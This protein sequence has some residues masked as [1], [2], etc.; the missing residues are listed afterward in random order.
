MCVCGGGGGVSRLSVCVCVHA[1]MCGELNVCVGVSGC[2]CVCM[3]CVI[4][5]VLRTQDS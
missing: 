2:V 3:W 1:C 4:A 5:C